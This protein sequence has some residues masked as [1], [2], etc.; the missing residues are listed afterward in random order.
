MICTLIVCRLTKR[1]GESTNSPSQLCFESNFD[2]IVA[3]NE[4]SLEMVSA[5]TLICLQRLLL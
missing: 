1:E 5:E 4:P 3:P 2:Y